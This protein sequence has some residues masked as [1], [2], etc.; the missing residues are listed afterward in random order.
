M[1]QLIKEELEEPLPVAEVDKREEETINVPEKVEES[2]PSDESSKEHET[3]PIEPPFP[4]E[5]TPSPAA[6]GL[7]PER[8]N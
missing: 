6:Q 1:A 7:S 8:F 4:I 3:Q 2:G 5:V